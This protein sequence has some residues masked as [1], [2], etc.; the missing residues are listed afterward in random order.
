LVVVAARNTGSIPQGACHRRL[1]QLQWWLL[2]KILTALPRG[3]TID[4]FFNFDGGCY[5]KYR[6]HPRGAA[7]DVFFNFSDGCY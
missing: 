5:Q 7:I 6:Q 1:L 2:P 4:V 3:A